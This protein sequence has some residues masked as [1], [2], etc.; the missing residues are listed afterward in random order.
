M[1]SDTNIMEIWAKAQ[2]VYG[3]DPTKYRKD[4]YGS[5]I[6]FIAYGNISH[7]YGWEIDHIIPVSMGGEDHPDNM[8]PLHWKRNRSKSNNLFI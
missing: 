2:V 3:Y 1:K 7:D 4:R 8:Q 6:A 5:W